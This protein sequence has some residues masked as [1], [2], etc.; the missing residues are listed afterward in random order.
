MNHSDQETIEA[1]DEHA[2]HRAEAHPNDGLSDDTF[3]N[4]CIE[5]LLI[6]LQATVGDVR[7]PALPFESD[8]GHTAELL[9][10]YAR[11]SHLASRLGWLE[12]AGLSSRLLK[13]RLDANTAEYTRG[14]QDGAAWF[15]QASA[16]DVARFQAQLHPVDDDQMPLAAVA[17]PDGWHVMVDP[18]N[19][20]GRGFLTANR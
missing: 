3:S 14:A 2:A 20:Y 13:A 12:A 4:D 5:C 7:S 18:N 8:D 17:L 11:I 19:P 1:L 10:R 9:R 6:E 15:S 16:D